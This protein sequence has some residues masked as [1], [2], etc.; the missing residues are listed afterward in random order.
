MKPLSLLV[1]LYIYPSEGA[2]DPLLQAAKANPGV[3]ITAIVNPNNGPGQGSLP[4]ANYV[5]TL[6]AIGRVSNIRLLGYVHCTYGRRPVAITLADIDTYCG[7]NDRGITIDGIF[8]DEAPSDLKLADW[9]NLLA[10][11]TRNAWKRTL[12][13]SGQV[14]LN[15]GVVV[16]EAFFSCADL[17][18]V[19]EQSEQQWKKHFL[20]RDA[21]L[22]EP[23][24]LRRSAA[25]IHTCSETSDGVTGLV[26][27]AQ[28]LGLG[29]VYVTEQNGGGYSRWP[30]ALESQVHA[31][32]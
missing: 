18:V 21:P 5:S 23:D 9:T 2:W 20:R 16:A 29:A 4:D 13:V 1:P 19:F 28:D 30:A 14:V 26:A 24:L 15:P 12:G 31:L 3:Q 22:I 8:L 32:A 17:V 27:K 25:I 10:L 6:R 7:W 11:H